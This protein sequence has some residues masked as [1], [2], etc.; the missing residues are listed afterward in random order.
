L[1]VLEVVA[2]R[3]HHWRWEPLSAVASQLAIVLHHLRREEHLR[4]E[5]GAV[6]RAVSVGKSMSSAG[7]TESALR[8]AARFVSERFRAPVAV[9]CASADSPDLQLIDVRGVKSHTRRELRAALPTLPRGPRSSRAPHEAVAKEFSRLLLGIDR[10]ESSTPGRG[11]AGGCVSCAGG[12]DGH[13]GGMLEAL[14]RLS[15]TRI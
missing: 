6:R 3:R 13:R 15:P 14:R 8:A 10:A 4:A 7:S 12:P 11:D 9:W 1:G 5:L 2:G